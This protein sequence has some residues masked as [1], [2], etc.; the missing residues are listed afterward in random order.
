MEVRGRRMT[1]LADQHRHDLVIPRSA[2]VG[3][4]LTS[5]GIGQADQP[6]ALATPLGEV[7]DPRATLADQTGDGVVL[8]VVGATAPRVVPGM[9]GTAPSAA[10][11]DDGAL[12]P[13]ATRSERRERMAA[14]RRRGH[15]AARVPRA[16]ARPVSAIRPEVTLRLVAG[17]L[18]L[19]AAAQVIAT[20]LTHDEDTGG[21]ATTDSVIAG[22]GIVRGGI[23][24]GG[25]VGGVIDRALTSGWAAALAGGLLVLAALILA[26]G[27]G[28]AAAGR[29]ARTVAP[30]VAC[31]GG[32]LLPVPSGP[33]SAG[34]AAVAGFALGAVTAGVAGIVGGPADGVSRVSMIA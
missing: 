19:A 15:V 26:L 13:P 33:G 28:T 5:L 23:V 3:D 32:L 2:C 14:A 11:P 6:G 8:T 30:F 9:A 7:L 22:G 20:A 16:E 17:G 34:V 12:P 1:V 18:A 24:G 4:V 10:P 25:I 31:A 27:T 21:A 29:L